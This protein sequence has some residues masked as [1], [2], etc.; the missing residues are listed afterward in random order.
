MSRRG[1]RGKPNHKGRRRHF[2]DEE[3]LKMELEKEKRK[4]EWRERRGEISSDDEEEKAESNPA[5]LKE[6][7]SDSASDDDEEAKPTGVQALI[8]I[9]NPNRVLQKTKKVTEIDDAPAPAQLSRRE[10]EEIA[11]QQAKLRYQKLQAEGKTDQAKADLA[12]LAIIRK[13]REMAAKK[14]EEERKAKEA[15]TATKMGK[16]K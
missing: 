16:G 15:A 6:G 11:K 4:E 14:R 2:T 9:E 7:D 10:K 5:Q 12:R 1:S 13:E 8:E 3:D